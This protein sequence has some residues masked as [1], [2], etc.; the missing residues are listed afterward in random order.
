MK[1]LYLFNEGSRAAIYGIGTYIRQM[2]T[3]FSGRQDMELN[4][5]VLNS[6]KNEFEIEEK[7]G[8]KTFYFP[9]VSLPSDKLGIYIRNSWYVLY[10]YIEEIGEDDQL[11]FHFNYGQELPLL[12]LAKLYFPECTT[13]FTIHYQMW[14]FEMNGNTTLFKK[15]MQDHRDGKTEEHFKNIAESIEKELAVYSAADSVICLSRYT[16]RLLLEEYGVEAKKISL[17]YNGLSDE[18][19]FYEEKEAKRIRQDLRFEESDKVI[20]FVGRLDGIKG[21]ASLVEAFKI[22]LDTFPDSRLLIVG[23]GDYASCLEKAKSI[24]SRVT[25]TGRLAKDE[26]YRLY[27]IADVGVMPSMHEQCSYVAIEMMMF[28]MPLVSSTSTGLAEMGEG[29]YKLTVEESEK[30]VLLSSE[31]LAL[32]IK[33][34]LQKPETGTDFRREYEQKY[35][36]EQ[37]KGNMEKVY[38]LI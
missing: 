8:Y 11:L 20:L 27:R 25:F 12:K 26:L 7:G 38:N 31:N 37:M 1:H 9:R 35:T 28:G 16:Y 5:V 10:S 13:L 21:V 23:E 3:V 2:I 32:L 34:A 24:W 14:C 29:M 17:V 4:V 36:L 30:E 6:D 19:P 22:V 33:E 15:I 18:C